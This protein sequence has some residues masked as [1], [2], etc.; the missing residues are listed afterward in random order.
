MTSFPIIIQLLVSAASCENAIQYF[1]PFTVVYGVLKLK[2]TNS[3]EVNIVDTSTVSD[4][5]NT[6]PGT[7][8]V[9]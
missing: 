6:S 3:T 2:D 7:L 8:L 5:A 1:V 9:P 4:V